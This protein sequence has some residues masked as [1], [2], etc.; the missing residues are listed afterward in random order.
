MRFYPPE[1]EHI[2]HSVGEEEG[3]KKPFSP[4]EIKVVLILG[5][6]LVLWFLSNWFSQ[7]LDITMITLL[8]SVA[9]FL[10][11]IR[12]ISWGEG[13]RAISWDILLMISGVTSIGLA[14]PGYGFGDV[15]G[16]DHFRWLRWAKCLL[17]DNGY[18]HLYRNYLPA[19]SYGSNRKRG[20]Y[21]AYCSPGR[22]YGQAGAPFCT[23]G[24]FH[25]LLR[26]FA[27][28]RRVV[29]NNV[30]KRLLQNV[31]YVVAWS[32]YQLFLGHCFNRA[33]DVR[34]S[35]GGAPTVTIPTRGPCLF[36]VA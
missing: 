13:S 18:W 1:I 14:R 23:P 3:H 27:A 24:D 25:S 26:F 31:R 4:A 34:S 30:F 9:I 10:T 11:G 17:A 21:S 35:I 5:I 22:K 36:Q 20:L 12:L 2:S 28:A 15:G 29:F 33:H 6:V 7:R 32:C 16:I 19:G 8:G